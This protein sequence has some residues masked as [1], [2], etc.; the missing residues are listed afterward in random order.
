M[1]KK[2]NPFL[3]EKEDYSLA[4]KKKRIHCDGIDQELSSSVGLQTSRF[5]PLKENS[6][7][8]CL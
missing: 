8:L 5:G 4:G 7:L 3:L 1:F 2:K 6:M